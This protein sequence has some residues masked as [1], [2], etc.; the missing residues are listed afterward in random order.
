MQSQ[1]SS[2]NKTVGSKNKTTVTLAHNVTA[3]TYWSTV[4]LS[5]VFM[6]AW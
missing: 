4:Q 1:E 2:A 6:A 3:G 5:S